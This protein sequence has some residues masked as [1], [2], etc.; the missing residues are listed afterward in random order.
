MPNAF[1][2]S[3]QGLSFRPFMIAV[4]A[5]VGPVIPQARPAEIDEVKAKLR[6]MELEVSAEEMCC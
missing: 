5:A 2:E 6:Q 3:M 4:A 1:H